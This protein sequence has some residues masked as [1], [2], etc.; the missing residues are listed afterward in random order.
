MN[1]IVIYSSCTSLQ[2][3]CVPFVL[4]LPLHSMC[5][6]SYPCVVGPY[7][8]SVT[9]LYAFIR[10]V[11]L[12]PRNRNQNRIEET[13][14]GRWTD[15]KRGR[16]TGKTAWILSRRNRSEWKLRH[17]SASTSLSLSL[18]VYR[19]QEEELEESRVERSRN[20]RVHALRLWLLSTQRLR[21]YIMV[22]PVSLTIS[23]HRGLCNNRG[24]DR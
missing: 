18:L 16:G 1:S 11:T 23:L 7:G 15:R 6:T 5:L 10:L 14:C 13:V 8:L 2:H 21:D 20:D 12:Y 22:C 24:I 17:D 3:T 9:G 4:L 19:V